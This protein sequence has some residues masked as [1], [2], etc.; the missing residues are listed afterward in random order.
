MAAQTSYLVRKEGVAMKTVN[1]V[2]ETK[3]R[4]VWSIQQIASVF[5]AIKL[6]AEK[7]IGALL[8]MDGGRP[9]GIVSER[10]YARKVVLQG[11]SSRQTLVRAI[12]SRPV[13]HAS[14][15]Q[16][17]DE[18]MALMTE[19]HIRHLPVLERGN[20]VGLVSIGD[21]VR[22]TIADQKFLIEQLERYIHS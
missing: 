10:D 15:D 21:L 5:D 3:G 17:I 14:P 16:T 1:Q 19:K 11:K 2:L 18:C 4:T 9:V 8:V 13:I 20:V 12:M 22:A 7:G 6:L